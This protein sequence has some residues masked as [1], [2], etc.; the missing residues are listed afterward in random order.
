MAGPSGLI[1][2]NLIMGWW[3]RAG[4]DAADAGTVV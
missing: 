3:L 1:S 4:F 2:F